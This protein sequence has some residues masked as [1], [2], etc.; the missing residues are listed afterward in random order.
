MNQP[1]QKLQRLRD[2]LA[3]MDGIVIGYSGGVD[4]T[5]LAKVATD[6][7]SDRALSVSAISESYAAEERADGQEFARSLGL[8]YLEVHTYELENPEYRANASNRC[9]FCKQ[10][11]MTHLRKIAEEHNITSV[12][13]G[14]VT[15]DLGDY[16]PGQSAAREQGACFP[17]IDADLS[18]DDIRYLSKMLDIPTWDKPAFACLSSRFPYGEEITR[19]KLDM[20]EQAERVL[21]ET[22]FRQFRVRHHNNLARIEVAPNEMESLFAQREPIAARL[23]EIGYTYVAMDMMGYRTGSMN[24]V[25]VQIEPLSV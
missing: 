7:L 3:R 5:F 24:E 6:V 15:D 22:G 1:E 21:R 10:E 12:A 17:L 23:K 19:E 4:S 2:N 13:L 9:Y 25:L 20:V 8:N 16:R 18:K 11:L 14:A